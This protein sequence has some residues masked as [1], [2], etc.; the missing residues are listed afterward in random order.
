MSEPISLTTNIP[1][2]P[3]LT[4]H[5]D[6]YRLITAEDHERTCQMSDDAI[7]KKQM[8]QFVGGWETC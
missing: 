5:I 1:D 7:F 3:I 6:R 4:A 8:M 2:S